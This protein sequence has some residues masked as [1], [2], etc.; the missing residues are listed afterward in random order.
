[1]FAEYKRWKASIANPPTGGGRPPQDKP[2]FPIFE[3]LNSEDC[4]ITGIGDE[5]REF[6]NS[7]LI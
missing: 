2:F 5:Y 6:G 3:E 1:M 7:K 4:R